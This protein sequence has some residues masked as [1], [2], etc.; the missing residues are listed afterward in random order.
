MMEE[1]VSML[2]K[3]FEGAAKTANAAT[4]GVEKN[5]EEKV[6]PYTQYEIAK[7]AGYCN[8]FEPAQLPEFWKLVKTT[9]EADDHRMNLHRK[10]VG[11]EQGRRH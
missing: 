10:N 9:K 7:L 3:N 1:V 5:E 4:S 2:L 8:E 11:V 6:K